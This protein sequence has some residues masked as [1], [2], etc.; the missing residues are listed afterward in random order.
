MLRFFVSVMLPS[1]L[2]ASAWL[3]VIGFLVTRRIRRYQAEHRAIQAKRRAIR[4][5]QD[6]LAMVIS[7]SQTS[8]SVRDQALPAYEALGGLL[9]DEEERE[10]L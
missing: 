10:V 8:I 7:D 3:S 6:V 9:E 2:I 4:Q 1:L 5:A